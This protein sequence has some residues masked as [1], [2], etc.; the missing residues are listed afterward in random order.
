MKLLSK[1]FLATLLLTVAYTSW[2][3]CP[4]G[5]KG[6][7]KGECVPVAGQ[8]EESTTTDRNWDQLPIGRALANPGDVMVD[9][10]NTA[11]DMSC[12]KQ[13]RT[14]PKPFSG[15][16]DMIGYMAKTD[17]AYQAER[18]KEEQIY[19]MRSAL[20]SAGARCLFGSKNGAL[21]DCHKIIEWVHR[22]VEEDA[23][24]PLGFK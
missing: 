9:F 17:E 18:D 15:M 16:P 21:S 11:P 2:A 19:R 13:S 20:I 22:A 23:F 4:E 6:N 24:K 14:L 12:N 7:Y 8:S 5:T 10:E 3:A 1:F